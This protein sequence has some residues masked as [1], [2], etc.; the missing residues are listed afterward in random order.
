MLKCIR[1]WTGGGSCLNKPRVVWCSIPYVKL[2]TTS[3]LLRIL[4][5]CQKTLQLHNS[6]FLYNVSKV[7]SAT[8]VEG[9]PKAPFSIAT[10]PR[11]LDF[12]TLPLIRTLSCWVLRNAASSTIFWV[13]GMTRPGIEPRSPVPL[14]NTLL[15]RPIF[16]ISWHFCIHCIVCSGNKYVVNSSWIVLHCLTR[17]DIKP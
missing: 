16:N 6:T 13:F 9:D 3:I 17:A 8:I 12:S 2:H 7:K 10:I 4:N 5:I 11:S 15:I 14:A 1:Y